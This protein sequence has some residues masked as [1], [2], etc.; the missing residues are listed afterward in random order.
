MARHIYICITRS[1]YFISKSVS[2]HYCTGVFTG[3]YAIH[4]LTEERLPIYVTSYILSE[5]GTGAVMGVPAHDDRDQ[6]FG[7]KVGISERVVIGEEGQTERDW[8]EVLVNSGEFSGLQIDEGRKK[9]VE[10]LQKEGLGEECVQYRLKDW[11][12][13]RQRYWGTPIPIIHCED[14]GAVPGELGI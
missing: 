2:L 11:L 6:V 4:P 8:K 1:R 12:I 3:S 13:S 5:Y 10:Y 7:K 14:C 9:I